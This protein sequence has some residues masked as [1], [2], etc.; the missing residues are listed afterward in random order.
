LLCSSWRESFS[1][2]GGFRLATARAGNVIGGGDWAEDRLVPD[3]IRAFAAGRPLVLRN[4]SSTRPWQHVL[5]PLNGYLQLAAAMDGTGGEFAAR[6]WNFGPAAHES[7]TVGEVARELARLWGG[8]E[9]AVELSTTDPH[10]AGLLRL[11]AQAASSE[12]G[13]NPRWNLG[14]AL[15]RTVD[16]YRRAVRGEDVVSLMRD[17]IAQFIR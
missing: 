2:S 16:W 8:G 11:D 5:D 1:A 4:P 3:A 15:R 7:A 13:W 14:E 12:L 17:Q 9:V 10:E 6:S